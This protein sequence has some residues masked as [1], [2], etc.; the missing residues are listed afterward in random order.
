MDFKHKL[1]VNK[2]KLSFVKNWQTNNDS[3]TII[4]QNCNVPPTLKLDVYRKINIYIYVVFFLIH[5]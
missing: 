5:T 3:K 2:I 1:R 4:K